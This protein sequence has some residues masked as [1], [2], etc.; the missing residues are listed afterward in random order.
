MEKKEEEVLKEEE[1]IFKDIDYKSFHELYFQEYKKKYPNV[2]MCKLC[3]DT[4]IDIIKDCDICLDC[5][6]MHKIL[7]LYKNK[8]DN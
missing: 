4:R 6:A 7:N 5:Y 3:F 8:N 1:N 2:T